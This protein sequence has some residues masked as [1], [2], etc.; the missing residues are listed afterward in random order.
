VGYRDAQV[1]Q[2]TG[3]SEEILAAVAAA[4][5][6]DKSGSDQTG[7]RG[8]A[9]SGTCHNCGAALGGPF[10][11]VCG[12]KHADLHKPLWE[13]TEDFLHTILHFDSRMW[14][15][16]KALFVLP[17]QLTL[18]WLDGRQMRH[19]P[20]I[21]LFVFTSLLLVLVL[22]VSDV[23]LMRL[24]GHVDFKSEAVLANIKG[25]KTME[26]DSRKKGK[27][28]IGDCSP[29]M[30][31]SNPENCLEGDS[32][33]DLSGNLSAEVFRL[34]PKVAPKLAALGEIKPE[35]ISDDPR[36]LKAADFIM[37]SI[38]GFARDPKLFNKAITSSISTFM[39]VATPL[40]A[41]ILKLFY[42]R[43]KRFFIEHLIFALHVHTFFFVTLLLCVVAVWATRGFAGG[44]WMA[45]GLWIAYS[46]HFFIA[47]KRAYGQGWIKT[48]FKSIFIT[49]FY[50]IGLF[51]AGTFGLVRLVL[52]H[53][54][55]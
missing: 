47:L 20:P 54:N 7:N 36:T 39:L 5:L 17:G 27:F 38:N 1:G 52:N 45:A 37:S 16:L 14:Q 44:G 10:C 3:V 41:I 49:G 26:I 6:E 40:M 23:A 8:H 9:K 51:T 55:G 13:L 12:Q 15:T 33:F 42:I 48:T 53:A 31:K 21:R 11:H 24:N 30:K 19:M 22:A 2:G 34:Q 28:S 46:L 4:T 32:D 29:E 50:S 35:Q 43:R 25:T 18:D